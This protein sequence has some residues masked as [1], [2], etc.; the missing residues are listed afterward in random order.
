MLPFQR[1]DAVALGGVCVPLVN[2]GAGEHQL[3]SSSSNA[4]LPKVLPDGMIHTITSASGASR[5]LSGGEAL[6]LAQSYKIA[7]LAVRSAIVG[8]PVFGSGLD[9]GFG[10]SAEA[11]V[12]QIFDSSSFGVHTAT[13]SPVVTVPGS[14]K[15][16][17][18]SLPLSFPSR[19]M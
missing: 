19:S 13:L 5:K 1:I 6:S 7:V 11:S 17:S 8:N 12:A 18:F 9:A 16:G 15:L 2:A 4:P 10:G 3:S 14:K